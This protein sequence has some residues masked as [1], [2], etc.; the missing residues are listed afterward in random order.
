[1]LHTC[2]WL[3]QGPSEKGTPGTPPLAQIQ[4]GKVMSGFEKS[5]KREK[6]AGLK[7]EIP[8]LQISWLLLESFFFFMKLLLAG[9]KRE[10]QLHKQVTHEDKSI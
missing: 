6:A 9:G 7:V 8:M 5:Y 3:A 2:P 10:K 1:M 4:L